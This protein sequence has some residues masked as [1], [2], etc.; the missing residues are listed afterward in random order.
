MRTTRHVVR[1]IAR[2]IISGGVYRLHT[3]Y[4]ATTD[5]NGISILSLCN[6]VEIALNIFD[7]LGYFDVRFSVKLKHD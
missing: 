6:K 2:R 7:R 3:A 5:F 4:Q 1:H